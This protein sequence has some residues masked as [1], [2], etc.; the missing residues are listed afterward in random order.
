MH[1][2]NL[3][4][5]VFFHILHEEYISKQKIVFVQTYAWKFKTNIARN[6]TFEGC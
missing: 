6:V 5:I 4:S 1:I 2:H 3:L